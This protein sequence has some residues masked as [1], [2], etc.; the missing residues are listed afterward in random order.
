MLQCEEINTKK[1]VAMKVILPIKK[2]IFSAKIE[3]QLV[4]KV[5]DRDENKKSHCIKIIIF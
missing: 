3:A 5:L 1:L 2:Y 4:K